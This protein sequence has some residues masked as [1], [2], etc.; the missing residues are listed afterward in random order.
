MG[1]EPPGR[2]GHQASQTCFVL[3]HLLGDK[4]VRWHDGSWTDWAARPDL[5]VAR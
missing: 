4:N 1:T 2:A 5:P 3:K